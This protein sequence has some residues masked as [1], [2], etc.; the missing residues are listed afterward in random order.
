MMG[1]LKTVKNGGATV[2][3]YSA[4]LKGLG[5]SF[6]AAALGATALNVAMNIGVM[7]LVSAG[8]QLISKGI[9][10]IVNYSEN[11]KKAAADLKQE[12]EDLKEEKK[13]LDT[14]LDS[15]KTNLEDL[16]KLRQ[17]GKL[18][19]AETDQLEYLENT[20]TKLKTQQE[21][22]ENIIAL[23]GQE[24]ETAAVKSLNNR[25]ERNIRT[26]NWNTD[27]LYNLGITGQGMENLTPA[28]K[29]KKN[30]ELLKDYE[31]QILKLDASS[32]TYK[33]DLKSLEDQQTKLIQENN[34]LIDTVQELND[35][36]VSTTGK[37]AEMKKANEGL[38]LSAQEVA[39]SI[40][41]QA[42]AI[43][44]AGAAAVYTAEI[45]ANFKET[46]DSFSDSNG[47]KSLNT[48]WQELEDN[49]GVSAET[50]ADL[51]DAYPEMIK[52]ID[53][54]NNSI[55]LTKKL[56]EEKYN[57]EKQTKIE[58]LSNL[59][60]E[61]E[62]RLKLA[63]AI[64][65]QVKANS[66]GFQ[67]Q[68]M[69]GFL[70]KN[71]ALDVDTFS[72]QIAILDA[73]I[74]LLNK[75][76]LDTST[77]KDKTSSSKTDDPWLEAFQTKLANQ[78]YLLDKD[79][80]TQKEYYSELQRLN[81]Y[82]FA[83]REKYLD[84]WRQYDV[85]YYA[86]MK[87]L[88]EKDIA[89][90]ISSI[91]EL[92]KVHRDESR[93]IT[94]LKWAFNN[95]SNM[96]DEQRKDIQNKISAAESAKSDNIISDIEH[97][98]S[99]L[100]SRSAT[101]EELISAYQKIQ[102]TLK[103]EADRYRSLGYGEDST[104]IQ[105]FQSQY[106][107][108]QTKKDELS[109]TIHARETKRI[110]DEIKSLERKGNSEAEIIQQYK[111][112]QVEAE[113]QIRRLKENGLTADS[114][115]I[116]E[117]TD[118]WDDAYDK[119]KEMQSALTEDRINDIEHEIFLIG[120]L[121]ESSGTTGKV[122]PQIIEKYKSLMQ[123]A[124]DEM[125][126]L[127]AQGFTANDSEIQN[128]QKKWYSYYDA[129]VDISKSA[130]EET[131]AIEEKALNEKSETI[132]K[133]IDGLEDIIDRTVNLIK[134]EKEEIIK[135][136]EAQKDSYREII[137]RRKELLQTYHD[138]QNYLDEVSGKQKSV[139][140][141]ENQLL[142]ISQD[143]SQKGKAERLALE[144]DLAKAKK[145]LT[146]YQSDYALDKQLKNLDKEADNYDESLDGQIESI[147]KYLDEEGKLR[148]DAMA[149]IQTD[150]EKLYAELLEYNRVYGDGVNT[151]I[152]NAWTNAQSAMSA[153]G[154]EQ[155]SVLDTLK[156]MSTA[157]DEY[158]T[159]VKSLSGL[160]YTSPSYS[161]S[162]NS[163][164]SGESITSQMKSNSDAWSKSTDESEKKSLHD[165]NLRLARNYEE[166]TGQK[167]TYNSAEGA[168]YTD[169]GFNKKRIYHEGGFVGGKPLLKSNEEFSKLVNF[170]GVFTP[171]S[172]DNFMT[173]T[174]P[175]ML[176][177]AGSIKPS[178][179]SFENKFEINFNGDVNKDTLPDL[180]KML[181][182]IPDMVTK[183]FNETLS[184][185][186]IKG[187]PLIKSI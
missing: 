75:T 119:V 127:Y 76:S 162:G 164:T 113:S 2:Q 108:Y 175:N 147:R 35:G 148:S 96:S 131:N 151:E 78:K 183:K 85:E 86:G 66:I 81:N 45:L 22:L 39:N 115:L 103:S 142:A 111:L 77:S 93:Y 90:Y 138:E 21:Y 24:A 161:M 166:V 165:A 61:L 160:T 172:M 43:E 181:E 129:I 3:G 58:T 135:S 163:M 169:D 10:Y 140:K 180:K 132:Q 29:I 186:G 67:Q 110:E 134:H 89:D 69:L 100:E 55:T 104:E 99:I 120:K 176:I 38:I 41:N 53:S 26:Q 125:S 50:M 18:T 23:K 171:K 16:Y 32:K 107:S 136:L 146:D 73:Q 116:K 155:L 141:I 179:G 182:S 184:F 19:Q 31:N 157:L 158:S 79:I 44:D 40:L 63:E 70:N 143:T 87:S 88:R 14:E 144:D 106:L 11:L 52:Y 17:N 37:N 187:N 156:A 62:A 30:I 91:E 177:N 42:E 159:K 154:G 95:W 112:L 84:E 121:D 65:I 5:S 27:S 168:W 150:G 60:A 80:I 109:E 83:G 72:E 97:Q 59:K 4:Y 51:I 54:E 15:V 64:Q 137:D 25:S 46:I 101:E 149:R 114:E 92:Y 130:F 13:S 28:E 167:L 56:I 34:G 33:K 94:D 49:W 68:R 185:R 105:K 117:W 47:V 36:I 133:Q 153:Y 12:Y 98:I 7:L 74:A 128:W 48:A 174:L 20:N 118:K 6:N 57:L 8:I 152:T 1:Y 71:D 123:I 139:S 126:K 82:Y 170:E 173:K 124:D 122:N 9:D 145:E 102:D 178:T